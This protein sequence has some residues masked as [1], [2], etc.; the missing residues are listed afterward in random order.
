MSEGVHD[1]VVVVT[2]ASG[3]VGRAVA[4]AFARRGA[5]VALLARGEQ[6]LHDAAR[7]VTD[8]GGRALVVPTDVAD[9]AAVE[10]AAQR[11]EDELGPIDV[12]VN[13]AMATVFAEFLDV[14]PDEFL[15]AT[16][17][18]YLGA[19]YG[20]MS[21]LRRMV[22]RDHGSVVQVGSAL[23]YRAIPLQSA[24]CGAKF[25][26][27]GFTDSVRTE[28]LH[29]KSRVWISMV[30]LPAV[31]TPQF[32]WCRTKLPDHPQPVP[33]IFQPEVPAE[34]VWWAAHHRRR[35]VVCGASA[36]VAIVGNKLAPAIADRYLARTGYQAQ[37]IAGMPV[38]P[39]RSSNLF[40]PVPEH[41][42]THGIFDDRAK[43][44]SIHTWVNTH[45]A[46]AAGALIG[47]AAVLSGAWRLVRP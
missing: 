21:A 23:S 41:A 44:R 19:V 26:M 42:A 16:Q 11:V 33:P 13:D 43:P 46:T 14:E 20:T 34:A 18:T 2:G 3:G 35:E 28:L 10:A 12:W 27:R 40:T 36:A 8:L 7:E 17:V 4:H 9:A 45:R 24:Y 31:N 47:G 37:Q 5:R 25:A 6:G 38:A 32:S 1:E 15:R 30:Q 29:N 22:P 39:D